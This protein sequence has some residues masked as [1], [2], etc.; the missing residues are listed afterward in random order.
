MG[1]LGIKFCTYDSPISLN[2]IRKTFRPS[3]AREIFWN[4]LPAGV[5]VIQLSRI[6][7]TLHLARYKRQQEL[8][9][10]ILNR[11]GV[12]NTHKLLAIQV[13]YVLTHEVNRG[14]DI[15]EDSLRDL[16]LPLCL[17]VN[18]NTVEFINSI[19]SGHI[20][21]CKLC[22]TWYNIYVD[23]KTI[24]SKD[25]LR[26]RDN[27]IFGENLVGNHIDSCYYILVHRILGYGDTDDREWREQ[28]GVYLQ[29]PDV[30]EDMVMKEHM[31]VY[32]EET[33]LRYKFK[34]WPITAKSRFK[35]SR[36]ISNDDK[37]SVRPRCR[38]KEWKMPEPCEHEDTL[39]DEEF[40]SRAFIEESDGEVLEED[41]LE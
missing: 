29:L 32:E 23:G 26:P 7:H 31:A 4:Y 20:A 14:I 13:L 18:T 27:A 24:G 6:D 11:F 15:G 19:K 12:E 5:S 30:K 2:K 34:L 39:S 40:L 28:C 17:H 9:S 35:R 25:D 37:R 10:L 1:Y 33:R 3:D 36:P 8:F 16:D 22:P 41:V 21:A 38:P